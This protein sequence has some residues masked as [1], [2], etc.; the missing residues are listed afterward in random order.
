[1][2]SV[3]CTP[4]H[5]SINYDPINL[6]VTLMVLVAHV[7]MILTRSSSFCEW[8]HIWTYSFISY[9]LAVCHSFILKYLHAH[10]YI[11]DM[12]FLDCTTFRCIKHGCWSSHLIKSPILLNLPSVPWVFTIAS[13]WPSCFVFMNDILF[14]L[15]SHH[16]NNMNPR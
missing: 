10:T 9:L 4:S 2:C 3:R 5:C 7:Q 15:T 1:M 12:F 14:Y 6:P 8:N 11:S 13:L 16:H